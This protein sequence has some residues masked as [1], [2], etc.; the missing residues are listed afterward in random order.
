MR[1]D[2]CGLVIDPVRPY[3]SGDFFPAMKCMKDSG[4]SLP[5]ITIKTIYKFLFK[6]SSRRKLK[7]QFHWKRKLPRPQPIGSKLGPWWDSEVWAR[8]SQLSTS[9]FF[10]EFFPPL[11]LTLNAIDVIWKLMNHLNM[12]WWGALQMEGW[13]ALYWVW[14]KAPKLTKNYHSNNWQYSI[15]FVDYSIL[16]IT[17]ICRIIDKKIELYSCGLV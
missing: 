10:T 11:I 13:A 5:V 7:S 4:L 6:K 3:F 1:E 8:S 12:L 9:S 15:G 17:I 2:G 14:C 16:L